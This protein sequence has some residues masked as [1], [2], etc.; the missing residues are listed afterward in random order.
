[1][2]LGQ[3]RPPEPLPAWA[4]LTGAGLSEEIITPIPALSSTPPSKGEENPPPELAS[5]SAGSALAVLN[6]GVKSGIFQ[7]TTKK[8]DIDFFSRRLPHYLRASL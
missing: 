6:A 8:V 5:V 4:G 1:M 3:P 2:V 7:A